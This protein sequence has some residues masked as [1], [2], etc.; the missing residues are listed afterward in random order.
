MRRGDGVGG[1]ALA[2]LYG[3]AYDG[4]QDGGAGILGSRALAER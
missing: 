1:F 4:A 3:A 2:L